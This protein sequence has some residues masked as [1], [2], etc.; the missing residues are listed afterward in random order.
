MKR[1][2]LLLHCSF[3]SCVAL[4]QIEK[5]NMLL[6]G[7]F[8]F[9]SEREEFETYPGSKS[10]AIKLNP[11]VGYFVID[12]LAGGIRINGSRTKFQ[13]FGS[14]GWE[15]RDVALGPF[16]RFYFLGNANKLNFFTDVSYQLG[17]S[18]RY[19]EYSS[20]SNSTSKA[21][22]K[23]YDITAGSSF[24]FSKYTAIELS[25]SYGIK[26]TDLTSRSKKMMIGL[27]IQTFL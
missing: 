23:E 1:L 5:G 9:N 12:Q 18:R 24:F 7:A 4:A 16:V 10:T 20:G 21:K 27:G 26:S 6:G 14:T 3:F 2:A 8:S 17:R 25:F 15:V 11:N 22:L 19:Q 13:N